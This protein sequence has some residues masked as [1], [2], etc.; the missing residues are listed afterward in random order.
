MRPPNSR[1][2]KLRPKCPSCHHFLPHTAGYLLKHICEKMEQR[3][4]GQLVEE[5]SIIWISKFQFYTWRR[6]S[7]LRMSC[8][9]LWWWSVDYWLQTWARENKEVLNLQSWN[10]PCWQQ[11]SML[12]E[13]EILVSFRAQN[14]M[15]SLHD[16]WTKVN[17]F[18]LMG[19]V[20]T[21]S[22]KRQLQY[23]P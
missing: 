7:R 5:D 4:R 16:A 23:D 10:T 21:V 18:M 12:S 15:H 13:R 2:L 3:Q 8:L 14:W 9:Q 20:L 11:L 6:K 19:K 17:K 22:A 1:C